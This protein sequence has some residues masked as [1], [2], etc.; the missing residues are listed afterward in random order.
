[1]CFGR[2]YLHDAWQDN[3]KRYVC[4]HLQILR[5]VRQRA[6]DPGLCQEIREHAGRGH[7]TVRGLKVAKTC[8]TVLKRPP[9]PLVFLEDSTKKREFPQRIP[10]EPHMATVAGEAAPASAAR[11]WGNA[12]WWSS[13]HRACISSSKHIACAR[14]KCGRSEETEFYWPNLDEATT[15]KQV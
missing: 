14:T 10:K 9:P 1:M 3:A 12:P 11:S 2:F 5:K 8:Y 6:S 15:N 7:C 13:L 4:A